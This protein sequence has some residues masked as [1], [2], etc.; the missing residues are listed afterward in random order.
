[1]HIEKLMTETNLDRLISEVNQ[2]NSLRA[3]S[4]IITFLGDAVLPRGGVIAAQTVGLLLGRLGFEPGAVRTAISRLSSDGWIQR[5]KHGRNSFLRLANG[6]L[7]PFLNAS[8]RIYSADNSNLNSQDFWMAQEIWEGRGEESSNLDERWI[9]IPGKQLW[10]SPMTDDKISED[11]GNLVGE[12]YVISTVSTKHVP[13][14]MKVALFPESLAEDFRV[15][16]SNLELVQRN[17]QFDEHESMTARCLLIH[18]WRRLKLRT[19][20]IADLQ[21]ENW[22]EGETRKLVS[23]LYHDLL[24]RSETW[25][26]EHGNNSTG[27]LPPADASLHS[28]LTP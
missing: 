5:E 16:K 22:P 23:K 6:R 24:E 15:L 2:R 18:E 7:E 27:S 19:P 9:E 28:R 12:G 21:P 25:L 4:L 10:L 14:W 13:E 20:P 26:D 3:W 11:V 8:K 1:M 17:D